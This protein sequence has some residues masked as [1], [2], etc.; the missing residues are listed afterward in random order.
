LRDC[1]AFNAVK[2]APVPR[3]RTAE[4]T[5]T[6]KSWCAGVLLLALPAGS[7]AIARPANYPD[8]PVLKKIEQK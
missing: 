1:A 2:V 6:R 3:F 4:E 7:A 8:R 5:M